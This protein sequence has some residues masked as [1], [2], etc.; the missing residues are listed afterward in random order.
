M[1]KNKILSAVFILAVFLLAASD[2]Y[3]D[4]PPEAVVDTVKVKTLLISNIRLVDKQDGSEDAL[5]NIL[6]VGDTLDVV[7]LDAVDEENI[8]TTVDAESGFL[9]GR[10]VVG[11]PPSFL[12]FDT[13]PRENVDVL[14]DTKVHAL[15]AMRRGIILKDIYSLR[16]RAIALQ[17]E[18]PS[19]KK[20]SK[21]TAKKSGWLA[22]TPPPM[23]LP[24]SYRNESKWNRWKSEYTSGIFIAA[25]LADRQAWKSQDSMSEQQ[26]GD[27]SEYDGGEIRGIRFGVVGT[28]N[29]YKPW[30]YTIF[31]SSNAFSNGFDS[32]DTDGY[33]FLDYR[34]DIPFVAGTN[35][36]VGKQKEP[37]SMERMMPLTSGA[38]QE[39]SIASDSMLR[40]RNFGVVL[41]GS[42]ENHRMTWAG[43]LFND[44]VDSGETFSESSQQFTGRITGLPLLS[45]D[46]SSL[47]HL[48][49]SWRYN[50]AEKGQRFNTT[51][52]FYN[53]PVFADTG[54]FDAE[55]TISS[56]LEATWRRGP[57]WFSGEY[58][59]TEVDSI[60]TGDPV[61][62]GYNLSASWI[63]SGEMRPYNKK[64][65]VIGAVP[66][67]S[68]VDEGG[69]G[70]WEVAVRWSELDLSDGLI[71]G[72]E[73]EVYS[74]GLNWWLSTALNANI[75]YRY[76]NLDRAN[77]SGDSSGINLRVTMLLQ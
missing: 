44:W 13:D 42:T 66:I 70:A 12:I 6:I 60:S 18:A 16:A 32:D 7:T 23:S 5:V 26:V 76:I 31:A 34:L 77:D 67:S 49:A 9:L 43:G 69:W 15:F 54:E 41:S 22:Y 68:S 1:K 30:I 40:A 62:T 52:E 25:L 72:G 28:L 47:L 35:L 50:D 46:E 74:L 19:Q 24:L 56:Q 33:S 11:E 64:S 29:F 55:D 3:S 39:R 27:L 20:K 45:E 14:L 57:I 21:K 65:G 71:D 8:G 73:V 51:P 63:L 38:M 53:S 37:I 75:N 10:L 36:S 4:T 17:K 48:G 2:G 58:L 61:F 59:R